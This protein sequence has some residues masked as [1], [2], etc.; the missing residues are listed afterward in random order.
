[1]K[2]ARCSLLAIGLAACASSAG[3]HRY[4][5]HP[6]RGDVYVKNAAVTLAREYW[7]IYDRGDGRH[8]LFPRPDGDR[9][10]AAECAAGGPK[11]PLF[12]AAMLCEAAS[13][14]AAVDRV[15]SL[16]RDEAIEVSTFLHA[17]LKFKVTPGPGIEPHVLI[18]DQVDVCN[19]YGSAREGALKSLC[20]RELGYVASGQRPDIGIG[21]TAEEATALAPLLND[22]Y[23]I[24]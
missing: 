12:R 20:D 3:P 5:H 2:T 19:T 11:A 21:F 22:L 9:A 10:I 18:S 23:G 15:N 13:S 8:Y 24:P 4:D 7:V 1:M 17:G 16:S 6:D 14:T